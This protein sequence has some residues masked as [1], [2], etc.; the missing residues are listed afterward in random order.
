MKLSDGATVVAAG[1]VHGDDTIV[2]TQTEEQT[3]K[4]TDGD[5][6][7]LKGRATGGVRVTKFRTET[8]DRVRLR[9]P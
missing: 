5:E 4:V 8:A 2:L 7:P 1:A 3:A 9:R 6:V